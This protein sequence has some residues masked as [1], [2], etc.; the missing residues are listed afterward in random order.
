M[1][2]ADN[3]D[4]TSKWAKFVLYL[5]LVLRVGTKKMLA[6]A[7]LSTIGTPLKNAQSH[8]SW[9]GHVPIGNS[10]IYEYPEIGAEPVRLSG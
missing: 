8:F 4:E 1:K 3:V 7:K 9:S 2:N 10:Q 5:W 6:P